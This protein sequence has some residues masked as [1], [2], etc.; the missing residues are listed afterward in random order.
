MNIRASAERPD[1]MAELINSNITT[2]KMSFHEMGSSGS[3]R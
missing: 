1:V 2:D 3:L